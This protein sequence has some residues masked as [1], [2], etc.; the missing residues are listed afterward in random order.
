MQKPKVF[1]V[2][3]EGTTGLRIYER[4]AKRE[5]IE[6]LTI[7]EEKRKDIEEIVTIAQSADI[8]FLCL[9]DAASK[10]IVEAT[11]HC[12][13]KVIDTSTAFRTDSNWAYGFPELGQAYRQKIAQNKYI[14]VPG[15]HAS[16]M[17]SILYPL[18][19]QGVL[20]P[21]Y[22]LTIFSLTGY[23]GGGKKMIAQYEVPEMPQEL[24]APRQY[25]L[26]QKHKHLKEVVHVCGLA[27]PPIFAPIVDNYYSGMEVSVGLHTSY[28][29]IGK[30]NKSC[31][32]KI[33]ECLAK[34]YEHTCLIKVANFDLNEVNSQFLN[35]N[36]K[37]GLDSMTLYVTGNEDRVIIHS[38]FDN[39]GKGASGAAVQCM[40]IALGLEGIKGLV[41]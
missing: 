39:L 25:G 16:G 12:S 17:I 13:C 1:I 37:T 28:L 7:A 20:L 26:G 41:I 9:P 29:N 34:Q 11:K 21:N 8:L 23:S 33:W 35:A 36:Q 5:D 40:N 24:M 27:Q 22:P 18:V 32:Q 31:A 6:I 10:E 30:D 38:L 15:C 2:G 14:A 19:Q 4:L 3:H